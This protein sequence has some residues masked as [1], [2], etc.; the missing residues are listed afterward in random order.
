MTVATFREGEKG[1]RLMLEDKALGINS[2]WLLEII[3]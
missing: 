2:K 1:A 3:K